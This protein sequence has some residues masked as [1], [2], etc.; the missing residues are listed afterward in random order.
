MPSSKSPV[1]NVTAYVRINA[2][3]NIYLEMR[4]SSFDEKFLAKRSIVLIRVFL[5]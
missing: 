4:N 2:T 3:Y 1:F 5:L